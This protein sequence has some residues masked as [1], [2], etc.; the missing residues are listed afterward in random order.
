M[1][2]TG[3]GFNRVTDRSERHVHQSW[4][5]TR[6]PKNIA[7]PHT[8]AAAIID[9]GAVNVPNDDLDDATAAKNG[10][11]TE[12]QRYLHVTVDVNGAPGRDLEVY[13]YSHAAG[14]WG[15]LQ[16]LTINAITVNTTY[17]VEIKG[18]DRVALKRKGGAWGNAPT[19]IFAACST[20]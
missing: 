9:D 3:K 16:T 14:V 11:V 2:N 10:Y 19:A 15:L 12:N 6:Q 17:V 18:A 8:T 13:A 4:G 20:F 1:A 7:G 5:R